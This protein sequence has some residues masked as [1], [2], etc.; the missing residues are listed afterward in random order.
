MKQVIIL[1]GGESGVGA[2][3]LAQK[4][5]DRPFVSDA[6]QIA[7]Q[8]QD[9]LNDNGIAFEMG[10]HSI[11]SFFDADVIVKSPGIPGH[12]PVIDQLRRRGK[13]IISEIEYGFRHCR[14]RIIAITGSNGK[15]TTASLA[16]HLLQ[17]CGEKVW[18]G[19][20]IGQ[21]FAAMV[22]QDEQPD[23]Y[24]LEVSSF[25][26]DDID[27]FRPE[28]GV[29]LNITPDHLDRYEGSMDLYAAAK[30]RMA[31]NQTA[32]D[33][34]L[35]NREDRETCRRLHWIEGRPELRSF[36]LTGTPAADAWLHQGRLTL[37]EGRDQV[38]FAIETMKLLGPHNQL[39]ALAAVLAVRAAS[40]CE[41][42]I[43]VGLDSFK[44]IPHRLEPVAEIDGVRYIND[45]KATN[46]DAVKYALEAMA[47]R[48][49]KVIWLAGG[50]DKGNDYDPLKRLVTDRV[51]AVV[52]LGEYE[53]EKF[54]REFPYQDLHP[55]GSMADAVAQAQ[56]LAQPGDS[57]LLSPACASF[58]LFQH[59]EDRGE[60]FKREVERL[61]A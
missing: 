55:V 40:G 37:R 23:W 2:A 15:T 50:I 39:N 5:G 7:A 24:V 46:V 41:T 47:D 49:G 4:V 54:R 43:R 3:L 33:V 11:E 42:G 52:F 35:Y 53:L 27:T 1:G 17:L 29:L 20:N 31:E 18:L 45:S 59:Y 25:Q 57:V 60:Q 8:Y 56:Q 16:H 36:G 12:V 9:I 28:V 32:S 14:S 34:F 30:L 19:G 58:D 10:D 51:R 13:P 21:S 61:R 38:G 44:P 6:G 48:E 22:A 26:L